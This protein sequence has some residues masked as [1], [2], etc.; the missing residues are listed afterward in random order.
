MEI[1]IFILFWFLVLGGLDGI[2]DGVKFLLYLIPI[3]IVI[4]IFQYIK[5]KNKYKN[6]TSEE[7]AERLKLTKMLEEWRKRNNF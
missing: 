3:G 7:R 1:I 5:Y 4:S 6:E 2:L